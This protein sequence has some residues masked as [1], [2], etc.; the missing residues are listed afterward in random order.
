M[1]LEC[2]EGVRVCVCREE[3]L[4]SILW[5]RWSLFSKQEHQDNVYFCL[6]NKSKLK[7]PSRPN[8]L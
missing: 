3:G 8:M 2:N 1:R 4:E 6:T 5:C 7:T